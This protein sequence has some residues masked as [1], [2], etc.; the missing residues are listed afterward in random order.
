MAST[1]PS[2][3][4]SSTDKPMFIPPKRRTA[5][6]KAV[7]TP[8]R[9]I[10][11]DQI[12]NVQ[13]RN[14]GSVD[15]LL[16]H[17]D[18]VGNL[19]KILSG[20]FGTMKS[21]RSCKSNGSITTLERVKREESN[22]NIGSFSHTS[23]GQ[24][25][26]RSTDIDLVRDAVHTK[27]NLK[28][29]GVR[30]SD[31]RQS[32]STTRSSQ[33]SVHTSIDNIDQEDQVSVV[34]AEDRVKGIQARPLPL[35]PPT[36][37]GRCSTSQTPDSEH[38]EPN[39][40]PPKLQLRI[41]PEDEAITIVNSENVS[42]GGGRNVSLKKDNENGGEKSLL[43]PKNEGGI[44]TLIGTVKRGNNKGEC[45]D[46]QL[47]ISQEKLLSSPKKSRCCCGCCRGPHILLI[48]LL[49]L[50]ICWLFSILYAFYMGTISW[51]NVFIYYNE[52]RTCCHTIFVSPIILLLY[53]A[54]II[55]I[56]LIL[57]TYS[58]ITLLSWDCTSL[59]EKLSDPERGFYGWICN[60]VGL[61]DCSPYQVVV[62]SALPQDPLT[63]TS[64]V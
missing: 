30:R 31:S 58:C 56:S 13:G 62:L 39:S 23:S 38:Q 52:Q 9:S 55:P 29:T 51:Y 4:S 57:G 37:H 44:L 63:F 40:E 59:R 28:G 5:S 17:E 11:G 20:S 27:R 46:V 19:E 42:I 61:P 3:R 7:N 33:P 35:L 21:S 14:P 24:I 15:C 1:L 8:T 18:A 10:Y 34:A 22:H 60:K 43:V 45:F 32:R 50:P 2:G 54:W 36:T 16:E 47:K 48:S 12:L 6:G 25:S 41:N 64:I 53:P 26:E 49:L